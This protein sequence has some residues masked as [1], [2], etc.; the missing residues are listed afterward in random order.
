VELNPGVVLQSPNRVY[1]LIF[2]TDG[3]LV[4]Y[5]NGSSIWATG[6]V[7]GWTLAMQSDGNLVLYN[8]LHQPVWTSNTEGNPHSKLVLQDDGNLVIYD[9]TSGKPLWTRGNGRLP[10]NL[11][12]TVRAN[13]GSIYIPSGQVNLNFDFNYIFNRVSRGARSEPII[14][15]LRGPDGDFKIATYF[16][17]PPMSNQADGEGILS[18]GFKFY[19]KKAGFYW[20]ELSGAL[21]YH[22][23]LK[24]WKFE[25]EPGNTDIIYR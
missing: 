21:Y 19:N 6:L 20:I 3:N 25:A 11:F 14:I 7:H 8:I 12:S 13:S 5:A 15:H 4:L 9:A 16:S 22:S 10:C 18:G 1:Q 17:L 24:I 23:N 2:Q